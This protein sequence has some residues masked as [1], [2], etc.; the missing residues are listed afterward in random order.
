MIFVYLS[1]GVLLVLILHLALKWFSRADA[2]TVRTVFRWLAVAVIITA[3]FF[4]I[5]FGL[6]HLAAILSFLS[7]AVP[8]WQRYQAS[9]ARLNGNAGAPP[10][11]HPSRSRMST[12]EAREILGV[13]ETATRKDIISAHR[14]LIQKNHPDQGGS[15]YLASKINEA[16][17]VLLD[18]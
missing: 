16:R 2:P 10:P 14:K 12:A 7:V 4:L 13:D 9:K 1:I 18:E 6:L 3:I 11:H 17:D 15:K 8:L 5:R